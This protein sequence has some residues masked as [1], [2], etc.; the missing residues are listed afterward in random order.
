VVAI[1]NSG[2]GRQNCAGDVFMRN[3]F[4]G[5]SSFIKVEWGEEILEGTGWQPLITNADF[6]RD[7][8]EPTVT[9]SAAAFVEG[10]PSKKNVEMERG[11]IP[12]SVGVSLRDIELKDSTSMRS[13][14]KR[15]PL[16]SQPL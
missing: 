15:R 3:I 11:G 8:G 4:I 16:Q 5:S 1:G 2:D 13:P 12:S 14:P 10:T 6:I 9:A 7:S